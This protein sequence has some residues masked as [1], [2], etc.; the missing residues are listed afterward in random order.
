[1]RAAPDGPYGTCIYMA[2]CPEPNHW[3]I[4]YT[5]IDHLLLLP[6]P[7]GS[8]PAAL[9][10]ACV[11]SGFVQPSKQARQW[12]RQPDAAETTRACTEK[13][14]LS[15]QACFI[16]RAHAH[17]GRPAT[18]QPAIRMPKKNATCTGRQVRWVAHLLH[19]V[20]ARIGASYVSCLYSS[21][22]HVKSYIRIYSAIAWVVQPASTCLSAIM[23]Y[24][25]FMG[26]P[27]REERMTY[28]L[29]SNTAL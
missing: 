8:Q 19:N 21:M 26:V 13:C 28:L 22:A 7:P 23:C 27:V 2:A 18:L 20:R 9:C 12:S 29:V 3:H 24:K 16:T 10:I 25:H 6:C 1:M 4:E 11:A 17:S 15:G 14:M 5:D